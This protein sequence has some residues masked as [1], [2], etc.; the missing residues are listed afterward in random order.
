MKLALLFP[1]QGSQFVGMGKKICESF[2][3][4]NKVFDEADEVLGFG[5]KKLCFEGNID[6]LTKTENTQPALLTASVA[7]FK[8]Y[9]EEIGIDPSYCA[10]HSLGEFSALTCAGVITFQDALKIV[11]QRGKFM[12]E[13]VAIGGGAMAAISGVEI[14]RIEETCKSVSINGN[15]A[16]VSNYNSPDQIVI[17]GHQI[18]ISEAGEILK[19]LGARVTPLKVSAPFHSPLMQTAAD[20]LRQ[21]L[22]KYS[23]N[24]FVYPV[25]S[26]VSALPYKN[27][28]EVINSLSLQI[29]Q[30]VQWQKSMAYLSKFGVEAAVEVG[31]Q[32]VLRNLMKKNA[33]QIKAFSYDKDED[34]KAMKEVLPVKAGA[35]KINMTVVTLCMANAVA[36]KNNNFNNDEYQKGVVETYK[37]LQDMQEKIELDSR[38]PSVEEMREALR[39][40]KIIFKTKRVQEKE[41]S[42]RFNKIFKKSGTQNV[43]SEFEYFAS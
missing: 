14:A 7:A 37:K 28:D 16:V 29:V 34:I 23:Y 26:N 8:V 33:P 27:K 2:P 21:E 5:L 4:A 12:Q 40:L 6:E 38:Q 3:V 42:D 32:T 1:G 36:T 41:Q 39:L 19:A 15:V 18:A 10:G 9:Q 22:E 35:P 30:P 20:K 13:A 17:S 31:P 43:F 24:D 25:I 11:R